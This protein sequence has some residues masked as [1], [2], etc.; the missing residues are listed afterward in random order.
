[1]RTRRPRP[2]WRTLL[3]LIATAALLAAALTGFSFW[4]WPDHPGMP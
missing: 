1:M 3:L 4:F 2:A